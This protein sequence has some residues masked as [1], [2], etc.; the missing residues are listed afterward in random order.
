MLDV[1][2]SSHTIL[3]PLPWKY[4]TGPSER[5]DSLTGGSRGG[6]IDRRGVDSSEPGY[7]SRPMGVALDSHDNIYVLDSGNRRVQMFSP[8]LQYTG[9]FRTDG[10]G[11]AIDVDAQ[12]NYIYVLTG[13]DRSGGETLHIYR[14][15]GGTVE[16]FDVGSGTADIDVD[17]SGN[18]YALNFVF[19]EVNVFSSKGELLRSFSTIQ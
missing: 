18:I 15:N 2:T 13:S 4:E 10:W 19:D 7:F 12:G 11:I 9:E 3:R 14:P 16:K 5:G 6:S 1:L 17:P 8:Q